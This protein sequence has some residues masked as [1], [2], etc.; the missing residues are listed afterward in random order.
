MNGGQFCSH[1]QRFHPQPFEQ[2]D[3]QSVLIGTEK[4]KHFSQLHPP[5]LPKASK[6]A[7]QVPTHPP[8]GSPALFP[9]HEHYVPRIHF[10]A[11]PSKTVVSTVVW[12]ASQLLQLEIVTHVYRPAAIL[13]QGGRPLTQTL[14]L[15][16][17]IAGPGTLM[18]HRLRATPQPRTAR[19]AFQVFLSIN[20]HSVYLNAAP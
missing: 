5:N 2:C 15:S 8:P 9:T 18:C 16:T 6:I 1:T 10:L 7:K 11:E 3:R 12:P 20:Q 14:F 19:P 17:C 13:T 4:T